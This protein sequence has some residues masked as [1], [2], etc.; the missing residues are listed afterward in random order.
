MKHLD[1]QKKIEIF[2][3]TVAKPLENILIEHFGKIGFAL[4]VFDFFKPGT[5]N[6][7]SNA[8]RADMIKTLRE[9]AD[10]LERRQDMPPGHNT[11]Q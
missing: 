7:I 4:I 10:R 5:G 3:K 11:I 2:L 6:Y 1:R 8:Q 9:T